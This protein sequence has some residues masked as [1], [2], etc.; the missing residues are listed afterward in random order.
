MRILSFFLSITLLLTSCQQPAEET[1][2]LGEARTACAAEEYDTAIVLLLKAESDAKQ[3]SD[4]HRL[5]EIYSLTAEIYAR[6]GNAV[7]E[8]SQA[9]LTCEQFALAGDGEALTK[10]LPAL[11]RAHLHN[12]DS[13][14]SASIARQVVDSARAHQDNALLAEGLRLLAAAQLQSK[15]YEEA[16]QTLL[17]LK[18]GTDSLTRQDYRNLQLAYLKTGQI[19]SAKL[20]REENPE[21]LWVVLKNPVTRRWNATVLEVEDDTPPRDT[22][23]QA[24]VRQ[25]LAQTVAGY[26][27][28]EQSLREA[29]L[30]YER[31]SKIIILA[32]SL[33][34]IAFLIIFYRLHLKA[35]RKEVEMRM[36][37][38]QNIRHILKT[39]EDD[40]GLMRGFVDRLFEQKFQSID[41]LCNTYYIY[42]G[43][44][45][46]QAKIYANVI[47][48]IESLRTDRKTIAE[49]E[50]YV[51]TYKQHLME[52]FRAEYP[53]LKEDDY[54][55]FLYLTVNFSARAVSILIGESLSVVYNRKS[56]LKRTIRQGNSRQ[57]ERFLAAIG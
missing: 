46:E 9:Q 3:R 10:T 2:Y 22:L 13:E 31:R 5:G 29:E 8:Q 4:A 28:Y 20:Y 56:R 32:V 33:V 48:Q 1:D 42:Q 24:L 39:T 34:I 30:R 12:N 50:N 15:R 27:T 45:N 18:A 44:K 25:H 49:L 26:R 47:E 7:E 23:N 55:L 51:N 17:Q 52:D 16:K 57:Q 53:H 19:D 41:E 37:E 21:Q 54:Q 14:G 11:G 40:A 43:A 6:V 38:A 35:H 36:L